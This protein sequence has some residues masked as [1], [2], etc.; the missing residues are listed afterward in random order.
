MKTNVY[1]V[2]FDGYDED[3]GCTDRAFAWRS[4]AE[5]YIASR[6]DR[7]HYTMEKVDLYGD[8]HVVPVRHD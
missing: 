5:A 8:P 7:R 1:V 2:T 6:S 4:D 3:D